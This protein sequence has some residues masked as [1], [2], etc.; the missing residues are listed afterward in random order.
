MIDGVGEN[1]CRE[2]PMGKGFIMIGPILWIEKNLASSAD[3]REPGA[4]RPPGTAARHGFS[5]LRP[6][7]RVGTDFRFADSKV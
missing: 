7:P 6:V 4:D 3:F 5:G 1:R 2:V